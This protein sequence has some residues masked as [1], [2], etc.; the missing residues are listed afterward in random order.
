[1]KAEPIRCLLGVWTQMGLRGTRGAAPLVATRRPR[2]LGRQD[3]GW[4][5]LLGMASA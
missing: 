1:M 4:G 3:G 2:A 5:G